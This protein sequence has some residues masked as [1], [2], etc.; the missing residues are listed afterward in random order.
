MKKHLAKTILVFSLTMA[1]FSANHAQQNCEIAA[2][3]A[4]LLLDLRIGMSPEQVQSVFGKTLKVKVKKKGARTFFQNYIKKPATGNLKGVR[5]IYLR[6]FDGRLYQVEIFYEPRQDLQS[7]E[8]I[9]DV[10]SAQLAVSPND[11]KL[12]NKKAELICGQ[13]SLIADNVLNP[14][15]ELTDETVRTQIEE[16]R[17]KK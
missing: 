10:L 12:K 2:K 5:A 11:W 6:F 13:N 1:A 16:S 7:L 8:E 9:R 15:V 3:S 4:P 17:K 14:R